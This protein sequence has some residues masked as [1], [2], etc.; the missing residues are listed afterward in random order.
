M[1]EIVLKDRDYLMNTL[2][3]SR[4]LAMRVGSLMGKRIA[5]T[6]AVLETA[7]EDEGLASLLLANE[8]RRG[9]ENLQEVIA[10]LLKQPE[11]Q[12]L[13]ASQP[14]VV[15][16]QDDWEVIALQEELDAEEGFLHAEET[17]TQPGSKSLVPRTSSSTLTSAIAAEEVNA[18][19]SDEQIA[20]L[21]VTIFAGASSS[22]RV[23]ALRR[24]TFAP[25]DNNR[26]SAILIQALAEEDAAL[27]AAAANGLH[28]LGLRGDV[29]EA[30]RLLAEGNS[31]ERRYACGRLGSGVKGGDELEIR[32]AVMA[33]L[34]MLR[35]EEDTEV[36]EDIIRVLAELA[37][38]MKNF[39]ALAKE[40]MR[41]LIEQIVGDLQHLGSTVR[42]AF[43]RFDRALPGQVAT[44]LLE[45]ANHTEV[46]PV[47]VFLL[48]VAVAC[49]VPG[50]I[51]PGMR[52]AVADC[53]LKLSAES[54]D[55]YPL[56]NYLVGEGEPGIRELLSLIPNTDVA[57]Q[58]F[59]IRILDNAFRYQQLSDEVSIELSRQALALIRSGAR[60][61][62]ADIFDMRL[63][64]PEALPGELRIEMAE[65]LLN[66][67]RQFALPQIHEKVENALVRLGPASFPPL[68]QAVKEDLANTEGEVACRALGRIALAVEQED[69]E[70]IAHLRS[71]LRVLQEISFSPQGAHREVFLAMGCLCATGLF[72]EEV[73]GVIRRNLLNRLSGS[74]GD[75][76][77]IEG[78]GWLAVSPLES[79]DNLKMIAG[80]AW[81]HL[82]KDT[83]D[84]EINAEILDG[85]EIFTIAGGFDV[86]SDLIPACLNAMVH[87]ILS[88]NL[89]QAMQAEWIR[90]LLTRWQEATAFK[91]QWSPGNVAQLTRILGLV[92]ES[93]P[94]TPELRI[95]IVHTLAQRMSNLPVLEALAGVV[96]AE[97]SM[98]DPEMDR[99]AAALAR[100]VLDI[101]GKEDRLTLEDREIYLKVLA[102]VLERGRFTVK[103]DARSRQDATRLMRRVVDE[104]SLGLR[105]NVP[106]TLLHLTSLRDNERLPEELREFI[107]REVQDYTALVRG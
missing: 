86:Y 17:G 93:H 59:F 40:I 96:A 101:M 63:T 46:L 36:I 26:R 39:P 54:S 5:C 90:K 103:D 107:A 97:G 67:M 69:A 6:A 58:R 87:V 92:G 61:L 10:K 15:T 20:E 71:A 66:G 100:R 68:L 2:G 37:P 55:G 72:D 94:I 51:R 95:E 43:T 30:I 8:L 89:P 12:G 75:A 14:L 19:F 31:N 35:V 64:T 74:V 33:L 32:A 81:S 83:P 84:A 88:P 102:R 42:F 60:L 13:A 99:L 38:Q 11:H 29:T 104:I 22:E 24:L 106:G 16:A 21:Q 78:L 27:R 65:A 45:E 1:L 44:Y 70:T 77:A 28:A 3:L 105:D 18:A 52:R 41:L 57:H 56:A 79:V 49:E 91:A 50:E 23:S 53:L 85:E 7:R 82:E 47:R 4:R 48:N 76:G 80:L 9:D 98:E 34:G 25:M 73:T 62:C